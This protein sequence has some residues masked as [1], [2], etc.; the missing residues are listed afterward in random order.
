VATV[1]AWQRKDFDKRAS[2]LANDG[3]QLQALSTFVL[4]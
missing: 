1:W 3:F 2:E 4:R